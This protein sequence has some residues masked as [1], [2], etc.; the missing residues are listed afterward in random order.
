MADKYEYEHDDGTSVKL[1]LTE[2]K[3]GTGGDLRA[4]RYSEDDTRM[5]YYSFRV[6][7]LEKPSVQFQRK[8][9][10]RP[11][12][13]VIVAIHRFGYE[14]ENVKRTDLPTGDEMPF[15]IR[16]LDVRDL[17]R[18]MAR[19]QDSKFVSAYLTALSRATEILTGYIFTYTQQHGDD[20]SEFDETVE[21]MR[22]ERLQQHPLKDE[23]EDVTM[24]DSIEGSFINAVDPSTERT[25]E[26]SDA[27]ITKLE[28]L[29]REYRADEN[30]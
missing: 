16:L 20:L 30:Q 10:E 25:T 24:L 18:D 23:V 1:K 9:D 14:I 4:Y 7:G 17:F 13:A 15:E 28:E 5:G 6:P 2:K 27:E 29:R 22:K 8:D 19:G 11:P 12:E 21:K 3:H 26:K